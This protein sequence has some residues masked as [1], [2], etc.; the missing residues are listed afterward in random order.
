MTEAE[1]T[2]A[3]LNLGLTALEVSALTDCVAKL[4]GE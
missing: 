1:A 3:C 2:V 4:T